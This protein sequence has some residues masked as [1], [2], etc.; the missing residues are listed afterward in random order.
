[1]FHEVSGHAVFGDSADVLAKIQHEEVNVVACPMPMSDGA[2]TYI[3]ALDL[4]LDGDLMSR[5]RQIKPS[6]QSFNA[7]IVATQLREREEDMQTELIY[8][9]LYL[10]PDKPGK[11]ELAEALATAARL[12]AA[13][14]H[15]GGSLEW[16]LKVKYPGASGEWHCDNL[17]DKRGFAT[18]NPT[19]AGTYGRPNHTVLDENQSDS[20]DYSNDYGEFGKDY[21]SDVIV[22][23]PLHLAIWKGRLHPRPFIHAEVTSAY[24]T[25]PRLI[26]MLG[27]SLS[28]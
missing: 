18:L 7:W 20:D 11:V 17:V 21:M 22:I 1:M 10:L 16:K 25:V 9:S 2:M 19:A 28:G 13:Q 14:A 5:V 3:D 8:P 27:R 12:Y 24:S 23:P 6:L 4:G 26:L 15:E